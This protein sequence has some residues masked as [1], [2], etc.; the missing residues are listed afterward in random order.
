MRDP[1]LE[2]E[3]AAAMAAKLASRL[4][5]PTVLDEGMRSGLFLVRPSDSDSWT[6]VAR[7][8]VAA[9]E[10]LG[11][12]V[13]SVN[14][15]N[16]SPATLHIALQERVRTELRATGGST[17]SANLTIQRYAGEETLAA[18]FE[19]LVER[20]GSDLVLMF[21]NV[22]SLACPGGERLLKALKAARDAVNLPDASKGHFLLIAADAM[23]SKL[24]ALAMDPNQAFYGARIEDFGQIQESN[25]CPAKAVQADERN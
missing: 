5:R 18:L 10:G 24:H 12:L 4:L 15:A 8:L 7:E 2:P 17:G 14:A 25:Y 16:G 9:L 20:R 3:S 13:I 21:D 11:A 19:G 6:C 1:I 23:L 22:G